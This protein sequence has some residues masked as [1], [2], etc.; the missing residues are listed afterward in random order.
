MP[1]DV[2]VL[3]R[4]SNW[5]ERFPRGRECVPHDFAE[6][7]V[8]FVDIVPNAINKGPPARGAVTVNAALL[9]SLLKEPDL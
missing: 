6:N 9:L 7:G 4:C 5:R 3:Q 8:A 1:I 2:I